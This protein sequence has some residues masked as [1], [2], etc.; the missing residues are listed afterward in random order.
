MRAV[1]RVVSWVLIF[2]AVGAAAASWF[3][4]RPLLDADD[5][6]T[7][8]IEA[9]ADVGFDGRVASDPERVTH[10]PEDGDPVSAWEVFVDVDDET[11]ELRVQEAAGRL[12]W[13]DD[14]IGPDDVE[15]L[16]TDDEFV[17]IGSFRDDSV[18]R[19]WVTRNA[20][21]TLAA[22]LVAA[23]GFA[24]VKRSDHLWR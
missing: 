2:G 19:G 5:A 6:S 18:Q 15:R 23:V 24:L 11:I 1:V 9:L 20:L 10:T 21:A 13:V 12:V 4:P 17:E 3:T 7:V 8:A 16:L 22:L 14:R